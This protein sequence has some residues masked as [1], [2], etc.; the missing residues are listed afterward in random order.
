MSHLIKAIVM[1][2]PVYLFRCLCLFVLSNLSLSFSIQ[3]LAASIV[4]EARSAQVL[5][6]CDECPEMVPMQGGTFLMGSPL[7]SPLMQSRSAEAPQHLVQIK[8]FSIG[9]IEVTQAQWHYIVGS[10]IS[11]FKGRRL[12]V[13]SISVDDVQEFLTK[14][15]KKTGR[16]YRL[17]T[18]AEWEFAARCGSTAAYGFGD[19]AEDLVKYGWFDMNANE[20]THEVASKLPN[21]CGLYDMHG[22]VQEWTEDC[23]TNDYGNAPNDGRAV[24]TGLCSQKVVRGGTWYDPADKLRSASRQPHG[25]ALRSRFT[26]FRVVR[27]N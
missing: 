11:A 15:S 13:E 21:A 7:G 6:D 12:P 1:T 19:K 18:E 5:K 2:R 10:D 17:P 4:G 22:N 26:G 25:Y 24:V 27:D 20:K 16:N 8:A 23:W 3:S 9:K 14:I